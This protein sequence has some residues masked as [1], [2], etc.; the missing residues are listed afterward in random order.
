MVTLGDAVVLSK[1]VVVSSGVRAAVV[2]SG[3][4]VIFAGVVEATSVLFVATVV[5]SSG[6]VVTTGAVVVFVVVTSVL[7]ACDVVSGGVT[8]VNLI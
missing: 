3:C 7:L 4:D 1:N 8:V 6:A 5:P 2:P